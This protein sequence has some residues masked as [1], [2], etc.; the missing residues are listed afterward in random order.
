MSIF[1]SSLSWILILLY[2]SIISCRFLS[3]QSIQCSIKISP[4]CQKAQF[5]LH[6]LH[7]HP[8]SKLGISLSHSWTLCWIYQSKQCLLS[9]KL[10]Y[11]LLFF[12]LCTQLIFL[13]FFF[14]FFV[15][16]LAALIAFK[17]HVTISI[18]KMQCKLLQILLQT[19]HTL[20]LR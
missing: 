1:P 20:P 5:V 19:G 3:Q 16:A 2:D 18:N 17:F 9:F 10:F 13:F 11:L 6:P 7:K 8:L 14:L 4:L 15:Q 12:C